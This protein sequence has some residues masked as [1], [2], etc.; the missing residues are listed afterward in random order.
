MSERLDC[1]ICLGP[2]SMRP[3]KAENRVWDADVQ[4]GGWTHRTCWDDTHHPQV[5]LLNEIFG[6]RTAK[7]RQQRAPQIIAE[8]G[9]LIIRRPAGSENTNG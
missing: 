8:R 4:P 5:L 3:E 9:D 6:N 2:I 7:V 1:T